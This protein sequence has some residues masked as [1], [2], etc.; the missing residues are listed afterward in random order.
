MYLPLYSAF[1]QVLLPGDTTLYKCFLLLLLLLLFVLL[2]LLYSTR[3][4][5]VGSTGI[6]NGP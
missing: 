6:D 3:H 1:E 4:M 5:K 2:L